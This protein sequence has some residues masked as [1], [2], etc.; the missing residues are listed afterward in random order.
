MTVSGSGQT[1]NCTFSVVVQSNN[2]SQVVYSDLGMNDPGNWNVNASGLSAP[3]DYVDNWGVNYTATLGV[4]QDPYSSSTTALQL[5]I[6]ETNGIQAGVTVSPTS[7]SL[8]GPF[9]MT[10]DM[11][12]N[13]NSGGFTTGS[14]QVGSYGLTTSPYQTQWSVVGGGQWFGEVTDNGSSTTYRGYNGGSPI[15]VTPFVAGSQSY[16]NSFYTSLFP[17]VNVPATETAINPNQYGSSVAGTVSFQWVQVNVTYNGGVLSESINGNLIASYSIASV[18][19]DIFLGM[20]D[21]NDG[22]AGVT[23]IADE[24]FVLF[25]NLVVSIPIQNCPTTNAPPCLGYACPSNLVVSLPCGSNCV[26]V[27]NYPPAFATNY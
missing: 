9:V 20:Y 22:S 16:A 14:T 18:G 5:K 6:N 17:S 19:P 8:T 2:Y 1:S 11:W 15:G 10:F 23:G 3:I 12:L 26:L 13:Y 27:S 25:D 24:N 21:V 7:L 4:P